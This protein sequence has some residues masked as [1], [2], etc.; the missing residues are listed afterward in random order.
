MPPLSYGP[1]VT[2]GGTLTLHTATAEGGWENSLR[3]KIA[4]AGGDGRLDA[5]LAGGHLLACAWHN[6]SS[7]RIIDLATEENFVL[8]LPRVRASA[9]LLALTCLAF[10]PRSC[11]LAAGTAS[12]Q[13]AIWTGRPR[14]K[15]SGGE[16]G[17]EPPSSPEA[18]WTA[19]PLVDLT[20][21]ST[22]PVRSLHWAGSDESLAAA[23]GG[24]PVSLKKF[25]L[26]GACRA[27][28]AAMQVGTDGV[29]VEWTRAGPGEHGRFIRVSTTIS[30][31]DVTATHLLVW[32][33]KQAEVVE[34][35]A[36]GAVPV[37][38]FPSG[39]PGAGMALGADQ[40]FRVTADGTIE[41]LNLQG[42]VKQTL[43]FE[44]GQGVVRHV[45]ANGDFLVAATDRNFVRLWR[46]SGREAKGHGST[47]RADLPNARALGPI[48]SLAVNAAGSKVGRRGSA[49]SSSCLPY[50]QMPARLLPSPCRICAS[51]M[52][53]VLLTCPDP[54][55][56]P[57]GELHGH[58]GQR[59]QVWHR[60][61]HCRPRRPRPA[62]VCV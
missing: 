60:R 2:E 12:G 4:S 48:A 43:A 27:E 45:A 21:V 31:L 36:Q 15:A 37:A 49:P 3:M 14:A 39:G 58:R 55:S 52:L 62:R 59:A 53:F 57:L 33:S 30:R 32:N 61:R 46:V 51:R 34:L 13:I 35:T 29:V 42:Q 8:P 54:S 23:T 40:V 20:S 44:E 16:G 50:M 6:E 22:G 17:V 1:Q 19:L 10:Q 25:T 26:Q 11:A 47:R 28:M 56:L 24:G 9:P 5:V 41:A 38:R 7:L 18:D